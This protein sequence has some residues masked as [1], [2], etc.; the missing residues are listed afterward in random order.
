[1]SERAIGVDLAWGEKAGTGL[2]ALKKGADGWRVAEFTACRFSNQQV[3]EWI[4]ERAGS[5]TVVAIDAPL[6]IPNP[7]GARCCDREVISRYNRF[8]I[9]VYPCNQTLFRNRN[10]GELLRAKLESE[11]GFVEAPKRGS[12]IYFETYPHPAIVNML[13][14]TERHRYKK[15]RMACKKEGLRRLGEMLLER[16]PAASPPVVCTPELQELLSPD[17]DKLRGRDLKLA[18]DAID[19]LVCAYCA[20]SWLDLGGRG[21]YVIGKPGT[22]MMIFPKGGR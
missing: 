7:T 22:G 3:L 17:V 20:A 1:M 5:R 6:W 14:L 8:K 18:E 13:D 21:N 12:R 11:Q 15:G 9:G 4:D 19:A 16:L 10:R 2:C